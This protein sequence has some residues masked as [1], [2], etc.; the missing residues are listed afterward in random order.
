MLW[1]RVK[2]MV[3]KTGALQPGKRA[4][5]VTPAVRTKISTE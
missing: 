5:K 4:K 1:A 3:P 2:V